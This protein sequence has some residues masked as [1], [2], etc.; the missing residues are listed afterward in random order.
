MKP[1]YKRHSAAVKSCFLADRGTSFGK[2]VKPAVTSCGSARFA[3]IAMQMP[4]LCGLKQWVQASAT[5]VSG[6]ASFAPSSQGAKQESWKNERLPQRTFTDGR[7][8]HEPAEI[9]DTKGQPAGSNAR[10]LCTRGLE[11]HTKFAKLRS[12]DRRCRD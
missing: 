2:R 8:G 12:H 1:P 4:C 9:G 7:N 6:A 10:A 3:W 11:N 5:K